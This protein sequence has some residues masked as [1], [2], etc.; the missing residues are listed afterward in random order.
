[1][2]VPDCERGAMR[3]LGPLFRQ[4]VFVDER[5]AADE[6]IVFNAGTFANAIAMRYS[7]FADHTHPIVGRFTW[8]R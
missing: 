6:E 5:L 7:D 1:M 2:D 4:R 8:P 3:P